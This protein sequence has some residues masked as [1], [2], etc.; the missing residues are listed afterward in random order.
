[1]DNGGGNEST[2]INADAGA[3][4][5]SAGSLDTSASDAS[6]D[7][8]NLDLGNMT[9]VEV[10]ASRSQD[11]GMLDL[12]GTFAEPSAGSLDMSVAGSGPGPGTLDLDAATLSARL[13]Q[14]A[15]AISFSQEAGA[16]DYGRAVVV[17]GVA[18]GLV[19]SA[20]TRAAG[21]A[22]TGSGMVTSGGVV[23]N[24]ESLSKIGGDI[25]HNFANTLAADPKSI[26]V[27]FTG[28]DAQPSAA[29]VAVAT[30]NIPPA[31]VAAGSE[32]QNN[33]GLLLNLGFQPS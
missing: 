7:V 2:G 13:S 27:Y 3:G 26:G 11:V 16:I 18:I 22:I 20:V 14:D 6:V 12:G 24:M 28:H 4:L 15:P 31:I 5:N 9:T 19:N 21:L 1:M 33:Y 29:G 30:D 25:A 32:A 10:T 17:A 23:A 8:G